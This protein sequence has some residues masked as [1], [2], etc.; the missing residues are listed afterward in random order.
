VIGA[1]SVP[2]KQQ[3]TSTFVHIFDIFST[4][5]VLLPIR[6][7][8]SQYCQKMD[9]REHDDGD[10]SSSGSGSSYLPMDANVNANASTT[11]VV[12]QHSDSKLKKRRRTN[13]QEQAILEALFASV[14]ARLLCCCGIEG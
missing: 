9:D 13:K 3:T 5:L 10:S 8:D 4:F 14:R 6:I 1:F 11:G 2:Q 12:Q 7:A